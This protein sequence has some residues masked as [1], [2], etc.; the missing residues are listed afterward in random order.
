MIFSINGHIFA[1]F[2]NESKQGKK[3][4]PN[5]MSLICVSTVCLCS[6]KSETS[7]SKTLRLFITL[8]NDIVKQNGRDSFK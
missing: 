3:K 7:L 1:D 2:S 6:C 4:K 5:L 8:S